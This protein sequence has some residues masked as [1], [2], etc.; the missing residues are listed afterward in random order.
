MKLLT[1][2]V[3]V[4]RVGSFDT[5]TT[6]HNH[7]TFSHISYT[8]VRRKNVITHNAVRKSSTAHFLIPLEN[9]SRPIYF[10]YQK[11]INVSFLKFLKAPYSFHTVSQVT[12]PVPSDSVTMD[13]AAAQFVDGRK[14]TA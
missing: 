9:I 10:Q 11:L 2:L 12:A 4:T 5:T 8:R 7:A 1:G 13:N 14:D 3:R 6:Q